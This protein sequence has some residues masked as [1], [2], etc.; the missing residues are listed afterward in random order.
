M[1][2]DPNATPQPTP[3]PA[4]APAPAP[5]P[6]PAP[7]PAEPQ[8]V[9]GSPFASAAGAPADGKKS[10]KGLI[11]GI[12]A[13]AGVVLIGV[14]ILIIVLVAGGGKTITCEKSL[15]S[16]G[17]TK[18]S[19]AVTFKFD[20]EDKLSEVTMYEETTTT[21]EISDSD[22]EEAKK[23]YEDYDKD[24]YKKFDLTK[25][26]SHTIRLDIE[27]NVEK[28]DNKSSFETPEKAKQYAKDN[29]FTCKD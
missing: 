21:E 12:C 23:F 19:G 18:Q 2:S 14:I 11:I 13:G 28:A 17:S 16:G 15:D 3:A 22:F 6:A 4:P 27:L 9:V 5:T 20:K 26:D 1:D 10:N 8:P 24:K 25:I 7:A 29:G